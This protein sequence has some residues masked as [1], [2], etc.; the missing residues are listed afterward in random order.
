MEHK[1]I[2]VGIGPGSPDYLPPIAARAIAA[3]R[4]L[5][6]SRRALETLAPP[7]CETKI[8]GGDIAGVMA[9]IRSRL[10]SG[11]V[12]V[13]V[14]GDPG[15]YSLLAALRGEFPPQALQVIPG[16][17]SLQVAFARAAAPWQ[18]AELISL[19]GRAAGDGALEYRPGKKLGILTDSRHSPRHIAGL[20]LA[21]GWPAA[22][23]VWLCADLSYEEERVL[24][25]DLGAAAQTEG[26]E[27]SV[28]VVMA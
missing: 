3:A 12:T 21:A 9:F 25:L 17:S 26:F 19:H 23:R 8:I 16:I 6:G 5:A 22:T 2:V 1:I 20:L 14:S 24:A 13:L 15:F 7:G 4:V 28:M 10:E 27:H 18:D 11:D